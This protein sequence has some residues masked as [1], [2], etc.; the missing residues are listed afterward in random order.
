MH[1]IYDVNV[2]GAGLPEHCPVA[3][4][5]APTAMAGSIEISTVGFG[6]SYFS[7]KFP[8]VVQPPDKPFSKEFS[9]HDHSIAAEETSGQLCRRPQ[10]ASSLSAARRSATARPIGTA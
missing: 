2:E 5:Q 8:A 6:F 10:L 9:R 1:A 7:L 4:S 3:V